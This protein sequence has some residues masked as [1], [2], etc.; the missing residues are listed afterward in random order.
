M[1]REYKF[2]VHDTMQKSSEVSPKNPTTP[3]GYC[4]EAVRISV[5]LLTHIM[6]IQY[7]DRN[8]M[9]YIHATKATLQSDSYKTHLVH[10]I[11]TVPSCIY[12]HIIMYVYI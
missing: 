6:Y 3:D 10:S 4:I 5:L 7:I 1:N 8:N 2:V 12:T 9:I 11:I